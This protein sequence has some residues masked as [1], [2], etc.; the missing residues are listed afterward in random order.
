[1]RAGANEFLVQPL[2]RT[3]FKDAV[4]R[5]ERAPKRT[6]SVESKLGRIYTF[7][8]RQGRRR[9]DDACRHFAAVQAQRKR[10]TVLMDLDWAGNDVAMQLGAA[11]QYTLAEVAENSRAWTRRCSRA[12][13]PRPL[14]M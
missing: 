13:S 10:N 1:M 2:K 11:P 14:G 5:Y 3:E 7:S 4:A 12:S 6:G 8:R 9:H